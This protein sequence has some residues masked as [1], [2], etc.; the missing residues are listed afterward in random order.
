VFQ[1]ALA[2]SFHDHFALAQHIAAIGQSDQFALLVPLVRLN[3]RI[4]ISAASRGDRRHP[5]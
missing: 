4:A 1:K 2:D 3:A 5:F